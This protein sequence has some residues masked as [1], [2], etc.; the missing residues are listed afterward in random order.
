MKQGAEGLWL[1]QLP[2]TSE[3]HT[4]TIFYLFHL[5]LGK[6]S[7]LTGLSTPLVYHL[8]RLLFDAILL[9]VHLSL[10][11]AVHGVAT[12]AAYGL[13]A[14]HLQRRIGLAA[15]SDWDRSTGWTARRSI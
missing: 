8:A 3:A 12:G 7:A 9:A 1:F 14:D 10:H 6:I 5:L 11:C 15:A 4:P 13:P 2:Y